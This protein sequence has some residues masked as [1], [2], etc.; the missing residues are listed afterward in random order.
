MT[1]ALPTIVAASPAGLSSSQQF[2]AVIAVYP[3]VS[4]DL[5]SAF[6]THSAHSAVD[7]DFGSRLTLVPDQSVAGGRLI[8]AP[9][10]SLNGDSDDVR[11]FQEIT[12]AAVQRALSAGAV[13]P[14]IHFP[15]NIKNDEDYSRYV[16]VSILGAL[17]ACFNPID[18]RE[19]YDKIGK[20][21]CTIQKIGI[22]AGDELTPERIAFVKAVEI[23]RRVAKGKLLYAINNTNLD[24]GIRIVW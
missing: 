9:T 15:V 3:T 2:D 5:F 24:S 13:A 7:K 23:G 20:S 22:V 16:E 8:L 12:K 21:Q 10:G 18:V 1:L 11:K 4:N 14:L 19:H 17:A 6:S